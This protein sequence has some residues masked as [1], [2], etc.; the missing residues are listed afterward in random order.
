[1]PRKFSVEQRKRMLER[2]EHGATDKDLKSEFKIKDSRTLEKQLIQG[3][4]EQELRTA[5]T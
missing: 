4:E 5:K 1:M 2:L 3:R